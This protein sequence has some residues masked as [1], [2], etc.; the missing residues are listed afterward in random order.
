MLFSSYPTLTQN[1]FILSF[2]ICLG[3]LQWAAARND[4]PAL[5]LLGSWGLG[6]PGTLCGTALTVVGFAWF[7]TFTPGLF[8]SGLAGGELSTLFVA[9]GSSALGITRLV[10]AVWLRLEK[11]SI[12]DLPLNLLIVN[13]KT[14]T[15]ERN[16]EFRLADERRQ[17][18]DE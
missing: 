1:Y 18:S 16:L 17:T 3:T 2:I 7:F 10:G 11:F 8:E 9:G 15:T 5:S 13:H 4:K 12:Y 14:V 6:W